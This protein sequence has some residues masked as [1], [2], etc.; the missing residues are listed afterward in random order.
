MSSAREQQGQGKHKAGRCKD[1]Y[2]QGR[3]PATPGWCKLRGPV[4]AAE[5]R[6]EPSLMDEYSD[7]AGLRVT[8]RIRSGQ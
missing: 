4:M 1:P 7:E 6:Q 8:A 3:S 5:V 2:Q